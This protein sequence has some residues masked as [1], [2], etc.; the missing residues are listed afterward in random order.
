LSILLP[1]QAIYRSWKY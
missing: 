1:L